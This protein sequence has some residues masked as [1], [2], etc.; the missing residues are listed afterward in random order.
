MSEPFLSSDEFDERAHQLYNDGQYDDAIEVLKDGL[1]LYPYAADLHVGMGYARLAR[2]EYAWARK[3]FETAVALDPNH[4][5]ALAGLGEVLLKFGEQASAVGAFDRIL[6]LGYQDD[7]DL[8]LQMGRALFRESA[9]EEA[10]RF[11]DL[12]IA[13]H[14]ESAEAAA[15]LGYSCHRLGDEA[16]AFRWLRRALEVDAGHAE[17]RIYLANLLYERGEYEAT[18]FHLERTDP[19]EHYDELAIWRLLELKKSIYRLADDDPEL[20]PWLQRLNALAGEPEPEDLLLAEI[21]ATGPDGS[22]RDPRQLELFATLLTELQGMQHPPRGDAHRVSTPAGCIYV[23]TWEEIVGQ[24]M[25]DDTSWASGT[26]Q[27]Y[28]D[29]SARQGLRRTGVMIPTTDAESFIRGSA[30]AGLLRI[31][32]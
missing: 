28:M 24:M 32:R 2:E 30:D 25:A 27:Q 4:E 15:C 11:F 13:A 12:A 8:M 29:A 21:E 1:S 16:N 9:L 3:S 14:P 17:A 6:G 10:R 5:D 31:L 18:L 20:Q 23:G 26:L 7:H 19:D 22:V